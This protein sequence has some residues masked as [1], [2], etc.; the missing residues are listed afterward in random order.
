[1]SV[2]GPKVKTRKRRAVH[3][4]AGEPNFAT[5]APLSGAARQRR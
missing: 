4:V 5:P 2:S 1:M 3:A